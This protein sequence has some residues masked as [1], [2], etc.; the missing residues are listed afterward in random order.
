MRKT[1]IIFTCLL[2]ALLTGCQEDGHTDALL[3]KMEH[4]ITVHPDSAYHLLNDME[5]QYAFSKKQWMRYELLRSEAQNKAFVDF[6]TDSVA[7]EVAD[8]YKSHGTNNERMRAN[9]MVGCAYRDLGDAPSALKYM[10]LAIDAVDEKSPDCDLNTLMCI[11]SQMGGLYQDVASYDNEFLENEHAEQI[12]W[13]I[14]D[15]LS[16][17]NLRWQRACSLYDSHQNSKAV[18]ILD[19]IEAFR[20]EY[21]LPEKPELIYP[22][23][24]GAHLQ[25]EDATEAGRLLNVYEQKMG[26]TPQSPDDEIMAPVYFQEKGRF[27]TLVQE[28]DSAI[29]MYRRFLNSIDYRPM[30]SSEKH[31]LLEISYRGLMDAYSLI[32]QP[33]SAI[34]YANMYCAMNDS[35]N[36]DQSSE[37]L[38]RMQSLYNYSK[39]QEKALVAEQ[40]ASNFHLAIWFLISIAILLV[41]CGWQSYQKIIKK[42]RQKLIDANKEYQILMQEMDKSTEELGLFKADSERFLQEKE[43]EIKKLQTALSIY[44]A[45]AI[46]VTQWGNERSLLGCKIAKHLHTLSIQ[47]KK[48]TF[49]ELNSLSFVASEGFPGF[50]AT[51]TKDVYGLTELET[52]ICML[53]RFRFIPS[54]IAVLTNHSSQRITNIKSSI[55]KK[56]FGKPGA[57]TLEA[58]LLSLK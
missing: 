29:I 54:E 45:N 31:G 40:R 1:A 5:G 37:Q 17:L 18:A 12:A 51:I 32:Q 28:A 50:Y 24:I 16:A 21:D 57:K 47:G 49:D 34:K 36:R 39:I 41:I 6:T 55:N 42:E 53:I 27:Y 48:A 35:T 52:M 7:L 30:S 38:L 58:N 19:S 26:I 13:Q 10:N 23:K 46:D 8:Y 33:D 43:T 22:I 2:L 44:Q 11:H 14:G 4:L 3:D 9:Y 20:K 56:I 15:T 25:N